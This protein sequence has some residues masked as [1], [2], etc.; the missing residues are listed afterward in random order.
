MFSWLIN[1]KIYYNYNIVIRTQLNL[2]GSQLAP[3]NVNID[4]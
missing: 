2:D 4:C 3:L 1:D